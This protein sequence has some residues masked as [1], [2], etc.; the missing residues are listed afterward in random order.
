MARL[1]SFTV[2]LHQ[3][4]TSLSQISWRNFNVVSCNAKVR[5]PPSNT[6]IQ[7]TRTSALII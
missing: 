2:I 5:A 4:A 1:W 7:I 6:V 3:G